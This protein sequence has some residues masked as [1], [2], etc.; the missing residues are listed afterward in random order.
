M[1]QMEGDDESN[2]PQLSLPHHTT[3]YWEAGR[4][5]SVRESAVAATVKLRKGLHAGV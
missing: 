5:H 2:R 3:R 1:V 4:S